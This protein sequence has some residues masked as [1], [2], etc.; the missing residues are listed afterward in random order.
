MNKHVMYETW[1]IVVDDKSNLLSYQYDSQTKIDH[2]RQRR[3]RKENASKNVGLNEN[4]YKMP[5]ERN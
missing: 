2:E 4:I 3:K 1:T 5:I